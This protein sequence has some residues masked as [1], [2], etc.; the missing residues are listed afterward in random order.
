MLSEYSYLLNK[1]F[2]ENCL[3][4][5]NKMPDNFVDLVVTSPPYG[6]LRAY[7]GYVFDFEPIAKELF[8]VIKPGGVLVWVVNDQTLNGSET[9]DSFRQALYFKDCGFLLYDTMIFAKNNFVPLTHN[10]YEQQFEYMFILSK[11]K[12]KTFNPLLEPSKCFGKINSWGYYKG[13]NE[14]NYSHRFRE[15]VEKIPC[16][17]YKCK[18]N[19]WYYSTGSKKSGSH[20]AAFPEQLATDHILSWSSPG[21]II[22]DPLGGSG[23]VA[24]TAKKNN[25]NY[26]ISEISGEYCKIVENRLNSIYFV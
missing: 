10:R 5:M 16:K 14:K 24:Y 3:I 11:G 22:F 7:N 18:S 9:G 1:V 23:T 12:P 4:T 21:E 6:K 15:H 2:N 13:K 26:I 19:I 17:E 20:V 25:R 8:R